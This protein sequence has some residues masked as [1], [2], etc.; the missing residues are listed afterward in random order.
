[1]G[2]ISSDKG[3]FAPAGEKPEVQ[4]EDQIRAKSRI[5][6]PHRASLHRSQILEI[7]ER[8]RLRQQ[9]SPATPENSAAFLER[10]VLKQFVL[11]HLF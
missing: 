3:G 10:R 1:M 11:I 9:N 6:V 4:N 8:F 7:C 2:F 5:F